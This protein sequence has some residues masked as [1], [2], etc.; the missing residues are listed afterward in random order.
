MLRNCE[1]VKIE[2]QKVLKNEELC[3]IAQ[4]VQ[5]GVLDVGQVKFTNV[6]I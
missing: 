3:V 6:I 5:L 2:V 1:L 4:E